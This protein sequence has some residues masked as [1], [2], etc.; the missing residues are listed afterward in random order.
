MIHFRDTV[1]SENNDVKNWISLGYLIGWDIGFKKKCTRKSCLYDIRNVARSEHTPAL[2][3]GG[4]GAEEHLAVARIQVTSS[5]LLLGGE[6]KKNIFPNNNF[7]SC[8][9]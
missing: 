2:H 1:E 7:N 5:R 8:L 4:N 3:A 6:G 9:G